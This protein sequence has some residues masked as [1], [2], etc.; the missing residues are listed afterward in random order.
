[1]LPAASWAVLVAASAAGLG[2]LSTFWAVLVAESA[3]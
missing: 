1:V 3:A 2:A